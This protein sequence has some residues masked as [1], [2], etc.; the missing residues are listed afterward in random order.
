MKRLLI[1]N[2]E[3]EQSIT[4][5]KNRYLALKRKLNDLTKRYGDNIQGLIKDREPTNE[6]GKR[7]VTKSSRF[8]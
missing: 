7:N 8:K 4:I 5:L 1:L 3:N 6:R 2:P